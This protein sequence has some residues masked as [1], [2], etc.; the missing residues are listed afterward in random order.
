MTS[1]RHNFH[2]D[3]ERAINQQINKELASSY[4]YLSLAYHFN[5]DDV[6]LNNFHQYSC[7]LSSAKKAIAERLMKL[8]NERGGRVKLADVP[9]PTNNFGEP[10]EIMQVL[11]QHEKQVRKP[12]QPIVADAWT[13]GQDTVAGHGSQDTVK[14]ALTHNGYFGYT[15]KLFIVPTDGA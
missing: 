13:D 9:T 14:Q 11:L 5:R 10:I 12:G 1:V 2:V 4:F 7:K 3:C 15:S 6:A 8:M